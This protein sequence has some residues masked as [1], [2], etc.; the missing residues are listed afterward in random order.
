MLAS[1]L[2]GNGVTLDDVFSY[3]IGNNCTG[4]ENI[5][6]YAN[7]SP[8]GRTPLG[9]EKRQVREMLVFMGQSSFLKWFNKHLYADTKD[10]HGVLRAISPLIRTER[11][12]LPE[13]EF[14]AITALGT[15]TEQKKLDVLK[16]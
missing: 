4:L 7:L 12:Q 9:D 1:S 2:K 6:F 10:I 3:V 15:E 8:T 11:K 13:E 5:D 16:K 14:L